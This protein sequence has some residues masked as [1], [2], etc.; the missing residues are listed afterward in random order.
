[1]RIPTI[2]CLGI[3]AALVGACEPDRPLPL[4]PDPSFHAGP[5]RSLSR[6]LAAIRHATAPYQRV[7]VAEQ[8]GYFEASPCV[9]APDLGGMGFHYLNPAYLGDG[10]F[11]PQAPEVL[12]YE[13]RPDD[14]L[15][16]VGVEFLIISDVWDATNE[17]P[18]A[19]HGHAFDDHRAE[20][21]R[22]GLPFGHYE[23]HV[24]TSRF[25]P[26]GLFAPF[27]PLVSCG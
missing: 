1:M 10:A 13:P 27:N 23:L 19:F 15:R 12:L 5:G 11:D 17:E 16:L 3:A 25:N 6:D 4:E 24:W 22:H 20:E 26:A 14:Q 2:A 8:D 18:P 9:S 7:E 21:L